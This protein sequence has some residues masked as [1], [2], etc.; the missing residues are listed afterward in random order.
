M[1]NVPFRRNAVRRGNAGRPPIVARI[2]L[3]R[4]RTPA[5]KPERLQRLANSYRGTAKNWPVASV[6]RESGLRLRNP[7]CNIGWN[8][9][10]APY[11]SELSRFTEMSAGTVT[12]CG[13]GLATDLPV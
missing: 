8:S 9:F 1:Q 10:D 4:G 13:S 7:T 6:T 2:H 3:S 11:S 12:G 5:G